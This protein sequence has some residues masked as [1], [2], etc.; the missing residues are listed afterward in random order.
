MYSTIIVYSCIM[1]LTAVFDW[2]DDAW[3]TMPCYNNVT[4]N[5]VTLSLAWAIV[6]YLPSQI[7]SEKKIYSQTGWFKNDTTY[8]FVVM[9]H[10][11]KKKKTIIIVRRSYYYVRIAYSGHSWKNTLH[12]IVYRTLLYTGICLYSN[13][14]KL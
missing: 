8:V 12:I 1:R 9:T 14:K 10:E 13:N 4:R 2:Q 7:I 11:T 6:L 3:S 5:I